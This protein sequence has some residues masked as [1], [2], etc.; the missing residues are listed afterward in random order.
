VTGVAEGRAG[1]D[2]LGVDLE[3]R[4]DVA[5]GDLVETS[6]LEGSLFPDG[7][8][9]GEVERV[10]EQPGG[11]GARLRVR[12]FVDFDR[13]EVVTVLRRQQGGGPVVAPGPTTT[14]PTGPGSTP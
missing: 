1:S 10:D 2:R 11:P 6:G 7:I 5:E 8:L 9:V 13:L 4:A 14:S 12:P 3:D